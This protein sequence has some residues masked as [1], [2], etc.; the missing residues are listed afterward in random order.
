MVIHNTASREAPTLVLLKWLRVNVQISNYVCEQTSLESQESF[1]VWE[2][3]AFALP[4]WLCVFSG[5]RRK[6]GFEN[7][8][9]NML[10]DIFHFLSN[11][12]L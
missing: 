12:F 8:F 9:H 6:K 5:G 10:P 4:S 2:K 7:V 1:W 3:F 11:P